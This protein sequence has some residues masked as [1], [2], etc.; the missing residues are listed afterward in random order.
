MKWCCCHVLRILEGLDSVVLERSGV[1]GVENIEKI[2]REERR[3]GNSVKSAS[4][5]FLLAARL[6]H[7]GSNEFMLWA[8][9][10]KETRGSDFARMP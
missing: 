4:T 3:K 5:S 9:L 7:V 8:V 1:K 2:S 10:S 6:L